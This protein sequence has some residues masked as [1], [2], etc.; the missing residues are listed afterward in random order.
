MVDRNAVCG[1]VGPVA[2]KEEHQS[3]EDGNG[4]K[5]KPPPGFCEPSCPPQQFD[6][7]YRPEEDR[8]QL[9]LDDLPLGAAETL[10]ETEPA[11][12]PGRRIAPQTQKASRTEHR[13]RPKKKRARA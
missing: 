13:A 1:R 3:S 4:G 12:R 8:L 6:Q 9:V 10:G 11:G 5:R 7:S 2:M